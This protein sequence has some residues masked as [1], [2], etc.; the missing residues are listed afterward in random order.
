MA[1]VQRIGE[2]LV[3]RLATPL[4]RFER[5]E[6]RSDVERDLAGTLVVSLGPAGEQEGGQ[7]VVCRF[8]AAHDEESDRIGPVTMTALH[9]GVEHRER[10]LANSVELGA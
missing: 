1:A 8:R 5:L 6:L 3:H 10:T 7:H 2:Q 4:E 9:D